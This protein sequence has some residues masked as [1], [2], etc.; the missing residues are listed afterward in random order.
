MLAICQHYINMYIYITTTHL[1]TLAKYE[2]YS[3]DICI[4]A[5]RRVT[6]L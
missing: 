1:Q 6:F 4:Q 3:T 5:A 2:V